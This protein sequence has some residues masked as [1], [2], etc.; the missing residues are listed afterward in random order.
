MDM[1]ALTVDWPQAPADASFQ[2]AQ[3]R[4]EQDALATLESLKAPPP[5]DID[6][7][8]TTY[9]DTAEGETTYTIGTTT[10][11]S[12]NTAKPA[13]KPKKKGKPKLTAKEKKERSLAMEK[14]ISC[15]PLEFRGNDPNLRR[16]METV[17]EGMMDSDGRGVKLIE[18]IAPPDLN[19]ARV[20]KCLIA[21]VNRKIVRKDNSTGS[22]L[23]HWHGLP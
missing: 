22:V 17:I 16:N 11:A 21:L 19:Q 6:P 7:D 20:N 12:A 10:N 4:A 3:R 1:N 8:K 2:L 15:L 13:T 5:S 18:L 9:T 23:Y 14:I